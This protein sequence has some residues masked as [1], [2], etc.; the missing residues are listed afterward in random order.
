MM[1]QLGWFRNEATD[2]L[3]HPPNSAASHSMLRAFTEVSMVC[4]FILHP[5]VSLNSLYY[6]LF[7]CRGSARV[8]DGWHFIATVS[9]PSMSITPFHHRLPP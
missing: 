7:L 1:T 5:N 4:I 6:H 9:E 2:A 8:L 3:S